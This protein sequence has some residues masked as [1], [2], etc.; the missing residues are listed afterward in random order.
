M[1][2]LP[3]STDGLRGIRMAETNGEMAKVPTISIEFN[4][5]GNIR[6]SVD[7]EINIAQCGAAALM[8]GHYADRLMIAAEMANAPKIQRAAAI[9]D[10]LRQLPRQ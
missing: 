8:I 9:P 5:D 6:F 1:G 4:P 3:I 7:P 10:N 2:A